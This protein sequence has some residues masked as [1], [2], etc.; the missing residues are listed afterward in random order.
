[1]MFRMKNI[2]LTSALAVGTLAGGAAFAATPPPPSS[3]KPAQ[4]Q[5]QPKKEKAKEEK[6]EA[7]IISVDAAQRTVT[8]KEKDQQ[9]T[10]AVNPKAKIHKGTKKISLDDVKAGDK[11]TGYM[12]KTK[13]G[14]EMLD[15]FRVSA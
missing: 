10:L 15:S 8:V 3:S 9:L 2:F 14:K 1:M 6:I 11:L 4:A 7:S 13:D 12:H 5:V